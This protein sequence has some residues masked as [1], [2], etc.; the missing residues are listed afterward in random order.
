MSKLNRDILYLIFEELKNDKNSLYSCLLVNKTW[1]ETTIPIL[2]KNPWKYC[3]KTEQLFNVIISHLSN[4]AIENLESQGIK[5]LIRQ[6]PLF[7]YINFCR[8]LNLFMF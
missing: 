6:K 2:W 8:Y 1:F 3:K 5:I 4:V 7:S